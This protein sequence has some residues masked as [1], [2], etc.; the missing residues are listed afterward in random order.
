MG[1]TAESDLERSKIAISPLLFD[2]II[3]YFS[4]TFPV[5]KTPSL[6]YLL[7]EQMQTTPWKKIGHMGT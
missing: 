3:V 1:F 7:D 4:Q 2:R 6:W 5:L